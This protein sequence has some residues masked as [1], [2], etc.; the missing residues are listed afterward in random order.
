MTTSSFHEITNFSFSKKNFKKGY[1]F[2][3]S[4]IGLECFYYLYAVNEKVE[5]EN[6]LSSDEFEE[7]KKFFLKQNLMELTKSYIMLCHYKVS[8]VS[9]VDFI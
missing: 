9:N 1:I 2:K 8:T 3:K 7:I 5:Q 6:A 4:K